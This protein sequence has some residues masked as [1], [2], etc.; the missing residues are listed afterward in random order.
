MS[1]MQLPLLTFALDLKLCLLG[2]VEH[3][4]PAVTERTLLDLLPYY[5]GISIMMN[6]KKAA[7]PGYPSALSQLQSFT[8]LGYV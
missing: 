7:P 1:S 6:W 4:A 5:A 2:L 8:L 3:M